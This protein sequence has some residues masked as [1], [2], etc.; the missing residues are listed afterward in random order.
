MAALG[1]IYE[2]FSR[3]QNPTPA[4]IAHHPLIR[5]TNKDPGGQHCPQH[6]IPHPC[7]LPRL[8]SAKMLRAC[9]SRTQ[10]SHDPLCLPFHV[11]PG[12]YIQYTTC[13]KEIWQK[14]SSEAIWQVI[15]RFPE[16]ACSSHFQIFLRDLHLFLYMPNQQSIDVFSSI[17]CVWYI[18]SQDSWQCTNRDRVTVCELSLFCVQHISTPTYWGQWW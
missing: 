5:P 4:P 11:G 18:L 1:S 6:P 3:I 12:N 13:T 7:L 14:H 16:H 9:W 10:Y 17:N 15:E 2:A 8:L